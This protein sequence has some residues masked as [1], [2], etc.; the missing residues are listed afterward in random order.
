MAAATGMARYVAAMTVILVASGAAFAVET[1]A[2]DGG[3]EQTKNAQEKDS[4]KAE[5]QKKD[6]QKDAQKEVT[7]QDLQPAPRHPQICHLRPEACM[8][9]DGDKGGD[10]GKA[11]QPEERNQGEPERGPG[12]SKD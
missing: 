10:Q 5:L 2:A 9:Q 12:I 6:T 7:Q 1:G 11:R 8:Q 4:A 3:A